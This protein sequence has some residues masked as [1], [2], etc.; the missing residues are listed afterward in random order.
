MNQYFVFQAYSIPERY[1]GYLIDVQRI[2]KIT[3]KNQGINRITILSFCAD[4]MKAGRRYF[5]SIERIVLTSPA[6]GYL[7]LYN[8]LQCVYLFM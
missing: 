1:T 6:G 3:D 2:V 5:K 7:L 4:R 8:Y